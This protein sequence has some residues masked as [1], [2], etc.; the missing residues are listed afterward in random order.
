MCVSPITIKVNNIYGVHCIQVPCGKCFE[1]LKIKQNDY[2]VRIREEM[3]QVPKSCFVTLTYNND[4]VPYLILEGKK[5]LCV[6]KKDVKDWIKR[7]R[8]NYE[9]KTGIKGVRYFL[10]SEYGP[11]THRP[12]YHAIFFGLDSK[13]MEIALNDWRSRFGFVLAKDV[14]RSPKDIECSAR[15]LSKYASKGVFENPFRCI[16]RPS[17]KFSTFL[18]RIRED[19]HIP[20]GC[21]PSLFIMSESEYLQFGISPER[22]ITIH[23]LLF[24]RGA[25]AEVREFRQS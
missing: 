24:G 17:E 4:S 7:F 23:E 12:H 18:K 15:Y 3:M 14:K 25:C 10:C 5:Y 19:L 16:S 1:C 20:Y 11:R 22:E 2:M 6:S 8:T 9:R 21:F 13:D